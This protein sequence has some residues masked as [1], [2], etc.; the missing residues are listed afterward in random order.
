VSAK[1]WR[2]RLK[3]ERALTDLRAW[4]EN[5]RSVKTASHA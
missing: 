3:S 4:I 5:E 2:G 1:V